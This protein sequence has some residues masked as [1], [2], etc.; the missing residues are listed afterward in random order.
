M[1]WAR[2]TRHNVS[3]ITGEGPLPL[4]TGEGPL[5]LITGEGPLPL[6]TGEGP[7]RL[8]IYVLGQIHTSL[9]VIDYRRGP[10]AIDYRRGLIAIDYRRGPIAGEGPLCFITTSSINSLF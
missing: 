10:I 6:I 7:L 5:P 8:H 2:Y 1:S 3:L 4:I 9:C